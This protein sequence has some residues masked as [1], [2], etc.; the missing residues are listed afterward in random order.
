M[1]RR[2]AAFLAAGSIG[3]V[4]VACGLVPEPSVG[5]PWRAP[6]DGAVAVTEWVFRGR[7]GALDDPGGLSDPEALLAAMAEELGRD[8]GEVRAEIAGRNASGTVVGWIRVVRRVGPMVG[9]DFKVDMRD[10][11][12][13]WF[14]AAMEA[15]QLCAVELVEGRC[16]RLPTRNEQ[17]PEGASGVGGWDERRSMLEGLDLGAMSE[18]DDL[19]DAVATWLR[20]EVATGGEAPAYEATTYTKGEAWAVIVLTETGGAGDDSVL[21]SQYAVVAERNDGGWELSEIH[22]RPVCVRGVTIDGECF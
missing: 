14:V 12:G 19:V 13:S 16:P 8:G 4:L 10:D 22:S 17:I 7:P 11:G 5:E 9:T 6:A 21:G 1:R 20:D 15:R 2:P 3:C 18:P